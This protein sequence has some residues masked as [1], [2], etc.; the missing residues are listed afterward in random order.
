MIGEWHILDTGSIWMKEFACALGSMVPT[1]NWHPEIRTFGW[2]EQWERTDR[3]AD[4]SMEM[5]RFPLQRGYARFPV[6]QLLPFETKMVERLKRKSP[7]P[8]LS[9]L[10][11][12]TPFYAPVAECWPGRVVYY[13]TDLTKK[14]AGMDE[15]QVNALDRRMCRVAAAVCPNSSRIA[16]YLCDE[17][18]CDPRKVTVIPNATREQNVLDQPLT[19]AGPLPADIGDLPRPIIGVIGNLAGNMDWDLIRDAVEK[20]NDV[21]WAFVGPTDMAIQESAQE[22]ARRDLLHR[23][24]RVRFVGAKKYGELSQ[25]ARSFDVALMPYRKHEPTY[26]GSATRFYEHLAAC[27]PIISS[28]GF[29]ELLTKEPLLKLIDDGEGISAV[30]DELR[31][32]GFRDGVE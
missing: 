19:A 2:W 21:S 27:R 18:G 26:S 25:Y 12:T 11:C 5:V 29:H 8:E 31:S 24:G 3:L 28:R 15:N 9:T 1:Q 4:P 32:T 6:A 23:G 22:E 13:L 16:Q 30:V 17:A 10:I 7:K 14:Y 20:T